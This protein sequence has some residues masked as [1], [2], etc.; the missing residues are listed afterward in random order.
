MT[1]GLPEAT[2]GIVG[3]LFDNRTLLQSDSLR[4]L[5]NEVD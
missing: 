5:V 3:G 2:K 4:Q 1:A